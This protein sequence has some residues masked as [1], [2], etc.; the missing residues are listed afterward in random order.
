MNAHIRGEDYTRAEASTALRLSLRQLDR[1]TKLK[2]IRCHRHGRHITYSE[3]HLAEYRL[4]TQTQLDPAYARRLVNVVVQHLEV[5]QQ[6]V[7]AA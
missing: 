3:V 1:E 7:D 6:I 4:L 2:R 5:M